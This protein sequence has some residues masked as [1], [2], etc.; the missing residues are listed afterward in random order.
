MSYNDC[1]SDTSEFIFS[2]S[3]QEIL[4]PHHRAAQLG[5]LDSVSLSLNELYGDVKQGTEGGG[6]FSGSSS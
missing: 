5:K 1:I 2:C 3:V 4:A 6:L